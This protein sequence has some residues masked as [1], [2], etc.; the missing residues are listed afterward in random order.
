MNEILWLILIGIQFGLTLLAFRFWGKLG[1]FICAVLSIILANIQALK[2]VQLFG[3]SGS[4][5][6]ISYIGIYL[7]SDILSENY[8]K[9]VAQKIVWLGMF[10]II[11][12][13]II[14]SI[15]LKLTPNQYDQAQSALDTIFTFFPRLVLASLCAFFISQSYDILAYQFWRKKFPAYKFIWLR[16]IMSTMFSQLLD[17]ALFTFSAFYGIFS[18]DY[19]LKIFLTSCV[20]RAIISI[21]DTPFVYW[22]V[23]IK[24]HVKEI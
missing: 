17:N 5:G 19:M 14:M 21:I 4:V 23:A 20:L 16:N 3:L 9:K 1:L 22:S 8:G 24:K 18:L 11:A 2:Q 15:S 13:T 12:V 6:D 7:I 10:S